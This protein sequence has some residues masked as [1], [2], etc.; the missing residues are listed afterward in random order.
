MKAIL[1]A[2]G[3]GTRLRPLTDTIPKCLVPIHGKPLL[4]YWFDLLF[5]S[6]IEKVL[7]N[8]HYLPE[9]VR[10]FV[11]A[12]PW[13]E[14]IELVHEDEILGTG[15]TIIANREFY[16]RE[17]I[18]VAHADNLTDTDFP[19]FMAAHLSRPSHAAMSLLAFEV[20]DPRSAG[21][22][23]LS[24]D[25]LVQQFHEKV[26]NPPGNLANGAVYILEAEIIDAI[27]AVGR[28]VVDFVTEVIP[29][30]MGR[31]YAFESKRFHMDIGSHE[32]LRAAHEQYP[33][34]E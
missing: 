23:E 8:T 13:R 16:S 6:G 29:D 24:E 30:F 15:G 7:V 9:P 34:P 22:L 31:I 14:K 21:I 10:A 19:A 12:S 27:E 1:L 3:F 18:L 26:D 33:K 25:N 17:P 5:K 11:N 20:E 4:G 2:A 32:R 28:P